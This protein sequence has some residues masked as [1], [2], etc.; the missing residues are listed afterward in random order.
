[1]AQK[2][3]INK[4]IAEVKRNLGI[5]VSDE[6][7][8]K[9]LL[10]TI[11]LGEFEK[12][13]LG[14]ELIFKGGTLLSRNYLNYH[15]FSEDLDFVHHKSNKLRKMK[16]RTRE[17]EIKKFIDSFVPKIY[18]L[19]ENLELIF[20]KNRSDTKFCTILHG[21]TVYIFRMYYSNSRFIKIEINFIE[22]II[23]KPVKISIKTITDLFDSKELVF[24][25]GLD[26]Q[27]FNIKSYSINEILIEKYRAILTRKDLKERDLFD[28]F[29]IPNSLSI[30]KSE[31]IQK[32]SASSLIKRD[33]NKLIEKKLTLLEK[34]NFF[35]SDE[36]MEYLA[37]A[38]YDKKKFEKFKEKIKPKLIEICK[39]FLS[40]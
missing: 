6:I 29:F 4:Y 2:I 34:N 36:N 26:I 1:M 10:L 9:D 16:R 3:N 37:I 22:K 28:L 27:N 32:I 40:K 30:K 5:K 14:K 38:N 39:T 8:E 23:H 11:I 19:A 18:T 31:I 35:E 33:L 20:S 13:G 24:S 25:L 12:L 21:R 15:R 7:I 17:K